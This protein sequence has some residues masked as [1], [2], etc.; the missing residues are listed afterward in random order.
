[1]AR[2]ALVTTG[3]TPTS[4]LSDGVD[5]SSVVQTVQNV[6]AKTFFL[7][8]GRWVDSTL[9]EEQEQKVIQITRYSAE[10]FDL[11]AQYGSDAAKYLAIE[12]DVTVVLNG[13][14]YSF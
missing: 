4:L 6:G 7:R 8:N 9:S 5:E 13:Q 14:A 1:M 2:P 11:I 10:Y 12:G 3:P